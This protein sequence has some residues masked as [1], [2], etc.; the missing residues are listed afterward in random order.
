ML[1]MSFREGFPFSNFSNQLTDRDRSEDV[2]WAH[3]Q[4]WLWALIVDSYVQTF[5]MILLHVDDT[6]QLAGREKNESRLGEQEVVAKAAFKPRTSQ[7]R[8][9]SRAERYGGRADWGG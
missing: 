9:G 6:A 1:Y 2:Q 7:S 3:D 8:Y 5:F 4:L